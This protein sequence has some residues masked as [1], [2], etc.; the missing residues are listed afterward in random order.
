MSAGGSSGS[1]AGDN[2]SVVGYDYGTYEDKKSD[3]NKAPRFNGDPEEF[4]W[5]MVLV[6]WPLMKKEL[7]LIGTNTLLFT[8]SF[9]RSITRSEE[10]LLLPYL[11]QSI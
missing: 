8:R 5:W 11:A 10:F 3:S 1:G 6:T 4:S 2:H 9:T 7:L